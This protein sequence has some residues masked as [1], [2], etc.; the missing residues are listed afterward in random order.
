MSA[1]IRAQAPFDQT[2]PFDIMSEHFR[3][4]LC[5]AYL[6]AMKI[7]VYNDLDN[8]SKLG[9]LIGG[10]LTGLIGALFVSTNEESRDLA[11]Q[12]IVD[13][14]PFARAQAEDIIG[15]AHHD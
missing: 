3:K 9:A 15:A 4:C 1:D 10:T 12:A 7:T 8:A 6:S 13:I 14:L 11:V 5:D 2:E